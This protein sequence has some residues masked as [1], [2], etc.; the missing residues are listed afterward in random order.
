MK[1]KEGSPPPGGTIDTAGLAV[2]G[3]RYC[4]VGRGARGLAD[5]IVDVAAP[6]TDAICCPCV[7][8][9][10][11]VGINGRKCETEDEVKPWATG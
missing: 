4:G 10:I 9:C 2:K 8:G 11:G 6:G 7:R 3:A 5:T 1:K